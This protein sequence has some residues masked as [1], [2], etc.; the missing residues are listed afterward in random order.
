MREYLPHG[1]DNVLQGGPLTLLTEYYGLG[2]LGT[3]T[4]G[5]GDADKRNLFDSE[6]CSNVADTGIVGNH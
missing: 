4:G 2:V 1:I 6:G 3:G 5:I